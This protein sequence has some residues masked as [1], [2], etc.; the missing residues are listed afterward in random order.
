MGF[1]TQPLATI[2]LAQKS[3]DRLGRVSQQEQPWRQR[4]PRG[5]HG[6]GQGGGQGPVPIFFPSD[7]RLIL[8]PLGWTLL[9]LN[10]RE[11][12]VKA[13]EHEWLL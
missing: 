10:P 9:V 11:H 2:P 4:H 13:L 1:P 3:E 7:G 5:V 6:G 12:R 8:G